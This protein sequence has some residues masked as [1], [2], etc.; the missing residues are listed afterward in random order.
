MTPVVSML[1]KI[2]AVTTGAVQAVTPTPVGVG[3]A[4]GFAV[5]EGVGAGADED[6]GIVFPVPPEPLH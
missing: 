2:P 1:V 4:D 3:E 6:F 5:D